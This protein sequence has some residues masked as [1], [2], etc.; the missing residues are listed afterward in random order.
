MAEAKSGIYSCSCRFSDV[1]LKISRAARI[2]SLI[3]MLSDASDELHWKQT[4]TTPFP[5]MMS[6]AEQAFAQGGLLGGVSQV[7]I[8]SDG[9]FMSPVKLQ[10]L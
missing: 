7:S 6:R 3:A 5:I 9:A 2:R 8:T 4:P 1:T 10:A